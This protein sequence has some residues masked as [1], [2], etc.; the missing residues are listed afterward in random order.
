MPSNV[1]STRNKSFLLGFAG[2][3]A[4]SGTL[5]HAQSPAT[6][7]NGASSNDT[8]LQEQPAPIERQAGPQSYNNAPMQNV[9]PRMPRNYNATLKVGD[10]LAPKMGIANAQ[11]IAGIYVRVAQNGAVRAVAVDATHTELRVERGIVNVS[12]H[13]PQQN[14][15]IVVDLAGGQISLLKD[16]LYTFNG[17]TKTVRVLRGEA[18]VSPANAKPIKIKEDHQL[19]FTADAKLRSVDAGPFQE[20]AD[21]IPGYGAAGHGDGYGGGYGPYYGYGYGLYGE[22]FGDPYFAY[23]YGYPYGYGFGYP[24]GGFGFGYYGG[25][26]GGF[27][28]GYGGGF[29]GRR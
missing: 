19:V 5:S 29:R 7:P 3:V 14:P 8:Y 21:F 26:G 18:E 28:G 20:R 12:V 6:G 13:Q 24:F 9:Q 10:V 1:F 2:L 16:G 22:G 25:F 27:R 11:P 17:D 23:G 15:E 4:L